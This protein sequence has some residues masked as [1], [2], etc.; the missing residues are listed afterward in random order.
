[1]KYKI[2][3]TYDTGDSFH[4]EYDIE[5]Y[6]EEE[7]TNIA[8][9]ETNLN[10]IKEH[11]EYYQASSNRGDFSYVR[12]NESLQQQKQI[13]NDAKTKPWYV[14]KYNSSLILINDDNK[15]FQVG[16]FWCGYFEKL[17]AAEIV[18]ELPKNYILINMIKF[19]DNIR[20]WGG[21]SSLLMWTYNICKSKNPYFIICVFISILLIMSTQKFWNLPLRLK[22]K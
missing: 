4:T 16:A 21:L 9:A 1:M 5:K 12:D 13:I 6:L 8:R 14:E 15:P 7:Y 11:Y 19:S 20:F 3:I 2:K 17:V 22:N 10:R 18:A